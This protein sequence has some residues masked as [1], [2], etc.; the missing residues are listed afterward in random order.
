M[1]TAAKGKP[2][3]AKSRCATLRRLIPSP[4]VTIS[5]RAIVTYND[6]CILSPESAALAAGTSHSLCDLAAIRLLSG[7]VCGTPSQVARGSAGAVSQ[8]RA[9]PRLGIEWSAVTEGSGNRDDRG[10]GHLARS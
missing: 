2:H 7:G 4:G 6:K 5:G 10:T 8:L 9:H 1:V 3:T